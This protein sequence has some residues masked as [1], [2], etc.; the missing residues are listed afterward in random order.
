MSRRLVAVW[1][2]AAVLV[3]LASFASA[4]CQTFPDK[5]CRGDKVNVLTAGP[6]ATAAT[7]CTT[8]MQ[9]ECCDAVGACADEPE[10]KCPAEFK[11]A[12]A[13]VLDGGPGIEPKCKASLMSP[14]SQALYKCVRGPKCGP[15]CGVPSCN[16]NSAVTLFGT[17]DCDRCVGSACCEPVNKCYENRQC[18]LFLECITEH[19]PNSLGPALTGTG[20]QSKEQLEATRAAVCA[21]NGAAPQVVE[22]AR[23][24]QRCLEDFTGTGNPD[25]QAAQCL[26]FGVYTCAAGAGCG[27]RCTRTTVVREGAYDEDL[28]SGLQR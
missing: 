27:A 6:D 13:C 10:D 22:N 7:D 16:L 25:D 26:A 9:K 14:T 1:L 19:C 23:C 15:T 8:C 18:K 4:S 11:Q 12:Q 2:L 24:F 17:A 20:N 21:T 28:D 3:A 5:E